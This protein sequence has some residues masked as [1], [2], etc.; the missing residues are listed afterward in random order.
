MAYDETFFYFLG[1]N[2]LNFSGE[3]SKRGEV[4]YIYWMLLCDR[5]CTKWAIYNFI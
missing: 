5:N 4:A 1:R 2:Y 3:E